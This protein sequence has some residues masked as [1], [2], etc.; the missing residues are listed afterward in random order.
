M[1]FPTLQ[2]LSI[3]ERLRPPRVTGL[4]DSSEAKPVPAS[5]DVAVVGAGLIGLSIA[6][7]LARCGLAVAVFDR[8]AA[9]DGASFAATGMLAAAAEL[10]PG[11]E[12]LLA[13]CLQS[14]R[15]WPTFRDDLEAA[16][17]I[18]IDYRDEGTLLVALGREEVERL[19]FR[20]DL[21]SRAGLSARW[22]SGP[23][24]RAIEPG[25]RPAV[26]AGIFC[27]DDH[28][29]DPRCVI[30]ALRQ[31]LL[32][33]GGSLVE[34]ASAVID[35]AGGRIAGVQVGDRFC[36]APVVVVATGAWTATENILPAGLTVPVRPLKGQA[37]AL[38]TDSR[39]PALTHVV[40][41]EDVHLAPKTDGRLI[42]GAT[43][44]ERGFDAAVTAGGLYALLEGARRALPS[45]EEMEVEAVWTGF[46][47]TSDDDAPIIGATPLDGLLIAT[48]HHRNG[49]LL[50]P[51]T[52]KA[53]EEL[54]TRGEASG[55]AAGFV[56][57]RFPPG[58]SIQAENH[59]G[60]R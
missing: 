28:Q 17:G 51:V 47:P 55:A 8:G 11:G 14:Q 34:N 3:G 22:V 27:S 56:L 49:V 53:V 18:Q 50:A 21:Q 46:R 52:A 41:T 7:R 31:A 1:P 59:G 10:E 26:T 37:L 35:Q 23:E 6:W 39:L 29:V 30:P 36:R 4:A 60:F 20:H 45:I 25:L 40:W 48:G 5:A 38:R 16:S 44:E 33:G 9:G 42:V 32:K 24:A 12:D 13:L 19:R 15:L 43:V 57:D 58:G 54:V 2:T